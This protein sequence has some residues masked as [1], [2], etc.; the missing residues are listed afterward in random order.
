MKRIWARFRAD[1]NG[2]VL[3]EFTLILIPVLLLSVGLVELG[4]FVW[5]RE[6]LADIAIGAARC[7]AVEQPA[8]GGI[9]NYSAAATTQMIRDQAAGRWINL[10]ALEITLEKDGNC[11]GV[12]AFSRVELTYLY[13]PDFD[14]PQIVNALGRTLEVTACFPNQ[15]E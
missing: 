14:L 5:T 8:C 10:Q 11:A 3:V 1:E 6:A 9:D 13:R 12:Q 4:R 7:M 2:A 15:G